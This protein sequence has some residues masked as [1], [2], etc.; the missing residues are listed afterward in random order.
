MGKNKIHESRTACRGGGKD[1]DAR[2]RKGKHGERS[3][4]NAVGIHFFLQR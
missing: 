3:E 2:E 1:S 4:G